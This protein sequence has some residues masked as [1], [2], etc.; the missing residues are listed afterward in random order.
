M[1][2]KL[3]L[4]KEIQTCKEL[5]KIFTFGFMVGVGILILIYLHS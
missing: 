5:S 2:T 4:Q 3:Q 1:D